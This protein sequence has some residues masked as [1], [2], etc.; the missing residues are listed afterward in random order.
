MGG[1]LTVTN[2]VSPIMVYFDRFL[3][4]S[5]LTLTAVT[6]YVTPF[7]VVSKILIVAGAMMGVLFPA[8]ATAFAADRSRLVTLYEQASRVLMLVMLPPVVVLFLFAPEGLALWLGDDFREASTVV[9]HW[10]TLGVMFNSA[11][12]TPFSVLQ[13][14]GRADLVAKAH[15]AELVPYVV[16]LWVLTKTFGIAGA[17]AAWTLRTGY[18]AAILLWLT[19]H[20]VRELRPTIDRSWLTL[21]TLPAAF[22]LGT[23]LTPF[24]LRLLVAALVSGTCAVLLWPSLR[25]VAAST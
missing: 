15:L 16:S 7:E 4:A 14:I 19:R 11:A 21:A 13:S 10:L 25:K 8:L 22:A 24:V 12:Q 20:E 6:Y 18:D 17:A 23:L 3:M 2:L 1:W 5:L 9:V